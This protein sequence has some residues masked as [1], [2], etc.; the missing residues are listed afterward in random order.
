MAKLRELKTDNNTLLLRTNMET[1]HGGT[2]G[3]FKVYEEI[4]QEFAFIV[5]LGGN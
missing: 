5:R 3:R 2:T 1:G 4:A